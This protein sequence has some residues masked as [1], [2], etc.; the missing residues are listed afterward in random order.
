MTEFVHFTTD[1]GDSV[2]VKPESVVA[3][4]GARQPGRCFVHVGLGFAF[5]VKETFAS[6]ASAL[7]IT[8]VNRYGEGTK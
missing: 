6:A 4:T 7:G 1:D 8:Y 3:I 5:F 2:I